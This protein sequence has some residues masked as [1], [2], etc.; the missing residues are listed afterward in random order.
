MLFLWPKP[1]LLHSSNAFEQSRASFHHRPASH[2]HTN[3]FCVF[4]FFQISLKFTG[5]TKIHFFQLNQSLMNP[6]QNLSVKHPDFLIV[7][8]IYTTEFILTQDFSR[9]LRFIFLNRI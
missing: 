5:T 7:R 3:I 8:P 4:N 1:N 6:D 2:V 9:L